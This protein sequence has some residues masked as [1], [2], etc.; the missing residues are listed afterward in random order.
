MK[1]LQKMIVGA[2]VCLTALLTNMNFILRAQTDRT[3]PD[4]WLMLN[5]VFA[6]NPAAEQLVSN[7]LAEPPTTLSI[8]TVSRTN[9]ST[10]GTYWTLH[11]GAP[12]P[13]NP[14]PD[15][16]VYSV[17]SNQFLIDDSSVDYAALDEQMQEDDKIAGLTNTPIGS[18]IDTNGLYLQ[19]PTNSLATPD[20]FT[21]NVMNTVV[22]Q[23]YDILTKSALTLPSWTTVLTTNAVANVTQVQVPRSRANLFV[24]ARESTGDYSF[25]V[26]MPPLSQEVE[27]GDAGEYAVTI[28]DGTNSLTTTSA[29]LTTDSSKGLSQM[30]GWEPAE[31][32]GMA[33]RNKYLRRA[34]ILE[35]D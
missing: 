2:L 14:Y 5:P 11:S 22:G 23:S 33:M 8:P 24:W 7:L 3:P 16:P 21:V 10:P 1:A 15:L 9:N 27:D 32:L 20:F 31:R 6:D 29:Q 12:L 35:G 4:N 26:N 28:S 30:S 19:V 17:S 25:Y 13:F 34:R 18:P